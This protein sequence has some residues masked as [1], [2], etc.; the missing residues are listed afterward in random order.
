MWARAF[1]NSSEQVRKAGVNGCP[2]F[3][4]QQP[5]DRALPRHWQDAVYRRSLDPQ[6][7]TK[8]FFIP[9]EYGQTGFPSRQT[10]CEGFQVIR[11]GPQERLRERRK[12]LSFRQQTGSQRAQTHGFPVK[13]V[14]VGG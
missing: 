5:Q 13:K 12:S 3:R 2:G 10:I 7:F 1:L 14:E 6:G 4:G 9:A 8:S 11:K